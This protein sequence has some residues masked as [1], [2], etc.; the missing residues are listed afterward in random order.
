MT[1]KVTD[2]DTGVSLGLARSNVAPAGGAL[3]TS[4]TSKVTGVG[5]G[6]EGAAGGIAACEPE[7]V[8]KTDAPHFGQ[9]ATPG[10]ISVLQ[11]GHSVF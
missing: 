1:E 5:T 11:L 2:S 9:N 8:W 10:L 3:L 4:W 6:A 7:S